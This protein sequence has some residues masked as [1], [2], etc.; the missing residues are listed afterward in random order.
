MKVREAGGGWAAQQVKMERRAKG[1]GR[2]IQE[3]KKK[4]LTGRG[5]PKKQEKMYKERKQSEGRDVG[6]ALR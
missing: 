1:G 6:K 3:G 5:E 4:K 2:E